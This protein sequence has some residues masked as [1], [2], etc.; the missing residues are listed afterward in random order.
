M[1]FS[2]GG[3]INLWMQ[4]VLMPS[5]PIL[6]TCRLLDPI[7]HLRP[8]VDRFVD[9]QGMD[10]RKTHSLRVVSCSSDSVPDSTRSVVGKIVIRIKSFRKSGL[11]AYA[12]LAPSYYRHLCILLCI[13]AISLMSGREQHSNSTS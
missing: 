5:Q 4:D 12:T 11:L 7:A 10:E 6:Q 9:E 3:E 2:A 13:R 1:G 8:E